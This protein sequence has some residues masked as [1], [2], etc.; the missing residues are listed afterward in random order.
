MIFDISRFLYGNYYDFFARKVE[1]YMIDIPG[2][3]KFVQKTG[4]Q[5]Q[6]NVVQF[7][8]PSLFS[9]DVS[10]T[11]LVIHLFYVSRCQVTPTP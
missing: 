7:L 9:T 11:P 5:C 3:K 10:M 4:W 2:N 8:R 6:V 1:V